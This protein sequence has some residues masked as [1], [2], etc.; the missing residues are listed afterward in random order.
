MSETH[1][2]EPSFGTA[3]IAAKTKALP[4]NPPV[5]SMG[6]KEVSWAMVGNLTG[7][8]IIRV[9]KT[10]NPPLKEMKAATKGWPICVESFA[11]IMA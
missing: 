10:R 4:M 1:A 6:L 8:A 2:V 7:P 5:N 3:K 11:L 9:R